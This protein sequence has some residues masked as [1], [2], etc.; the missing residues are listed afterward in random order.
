MS[1]SLSAESHKLLSALDVHVVEL[2]RS[3]QGHKDLSSAKGYL[4]SRLEKLESDLQLS[5]ALVQSSKQALCT[6]AKSSLKPDVRLVASGGTEF[7]MDEP[8]L[9]Q[10]SPYFAGVLCGG[11]AEQESRVVKFD[12]VEPEVLE[13]VC[14]AIRSGSHPEAAFESCLPAS[15]LVKALELCVRIQLPDTFVEANADA[16]IAKLDDL[17]IPVA[18][19]LLAASELHSESGAENLRGKWQ[20]LKDTA[21]Q[22]IAF[23]LE[24]ASDEQLGSLSAGQMLLVLNDIADKKLDPV[25]VASP[26]VSEEHTSSGMLPLGSLNFRLLV[27]YKEGYLSATVCPLAACFVEGTEISLDPPPG[28]SKLG[29]MRCFPADAW[30]DKCAV[31]GLSRFCTGFVIKDYLHEDGKLQFSVSICLAKQERRINLIV[32]WVSMQE[33]YDGPKTPCHALRWLARVLYVPGS[34]GHDAALRNLGEK[35]NRLLVRYTAG[36]FFAQKDLDALPANVFVKILEHS[37][38]RTAAAKEDESELNVL[39]AVLDWALCNREFSVGADVRIKETG[40]IAKVLEVCG[41]EY[42]VYMEAEGEKEANHDLLNIEELASV[43]TMLP[44]LLNQVKF[45]F[46]VM[47]DLVNTLS[48]PQWEILNACPRFKELGE[49]ATEFQ[50]KKRS[51]ASP[52]SGDLGKR[53]QKRARQASDIPSLSASQIFGGLIGQRQDTASV[54]SP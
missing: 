23:K 33:S 28:S 31:S 48:A 10:N 47:S 44:M 19:D 25:A 2:H 27:L 5:N 9:K 11:F 35:M 6:A 12:D 51:L 17:G 8:T 21:M 15:V 20:E 52:G 45:P 34:L 38:L 29:Q 4:A 26:E 36:S 16:I 40:R 49:Q 42:G 43:D 24:E 37:R 46:I 14:V 22:A 54:V 13:C 41:G 7:L 3:N 1:M 30:V 32:K 18:L 39:C 50:I 53:H